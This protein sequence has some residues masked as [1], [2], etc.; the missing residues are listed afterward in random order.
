MAVVDKGRV[1]EGYVSGKPEIERQARLRYESTDGYQSRLQSHYREM[2]HWF[3]PDDGDHWPDDATIRPGKI[4]V[5]TNICLPI[6]KIDSRL[7]S[8]LPRFTLPTSA[9]SAEDRKRAEAT[10]IIIKLWLDMSGI[11]VWLTD[12]C[13]VRSIY[14]KGVLK[15][16]WDDELQ[17]GDVINIENP[18]NL[19]IGWGSSDYTRID[20]TIYEYSLSR[21]EITQ[22]WP[23]VRIEKPVDDTLPPK[24]IVEGGDHSDPLD[25]KLVSFWSPK[26][27]QYTDYERTQVKVWDYWYK[28]ED[29]DVVNSILVGGKIVEGPTKHTE[30]PDIPYIPIENDHEPGNPEGISTIEPLIDLQEE[31]NRLMSHGLQ[32]IADNVDPAW[33]ATGPTA[34]ALEPGVAPKA[35]EIVGIGEN[36][37]EEWPKGI[38]GSFPVKDMMDS[39]WEYYRRMTGI[40]DIA[41]GDMPSADVSGR[42]VAIQVESMMN[43]LDPRRRRLYRGLKELIAFWI[44]MAERKNPK[45]RVDQENETNLGD[46]VKDMRYW[47]I[48]P[49]EITPRD[50]FEVTQNEINKVNAKMSSLRSGM[51]AIGIEAPE[52]ELSVVAAEHND[53]DVHP[54]SVQ[55]KFG[56]YSMMMQLQQQMQQLQQQQAQFQQLQQAQAQQGGVGGSPGSALAQAQGATAQGLQAQQAAQPTGFNDQNQPLTQAGT[57]PPQGAGA[58]GTGQATQIIRP[59]Q[60]GQALNQVAFNSPIGG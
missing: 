32:Y 18:A 19:R 16:Y 10:E 28:D 56:V 17:R 60:G 48:I 5:T 46:L 53:I 15:P 25:Q 40:S 33:Y 4:H 58:Q 8:I 9:L 26:Y 38:S 12:L 27:R 52:H 21:H 34:D 2:H 47:K 44:I 23:F 13:Q 35:G 50:N 39:V 57:P 55:I 49:P 45:V 59:N 30:L 42:A 14:G 36:R 51:D 22:R 7:Q 11:D 6:V 54:D 20:W 1:L 29:G 41:F 24:V 43:R 3:L 31:L 37:V